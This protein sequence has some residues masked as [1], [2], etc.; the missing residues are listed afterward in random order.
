MAEKKFME[1]RLGITEGSVSF[2]ILVLVRSALANYPAGTLLSCP[3]Y[4][5]VPFLV[6]SPLRAYIVGVRR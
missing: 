6:Y 4:L 3:L 5:H 1:D 2:R